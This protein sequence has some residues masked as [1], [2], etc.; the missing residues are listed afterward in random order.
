MTDVYST[1]RSRQATADCASLDIRRWT[2]SESDEGALVKHER[3]DHLGYGAPTEHRAQI[4]AAA[5]MPRDGRRAGLFP[6]DSQYRFIAVD[7][8][9]L[10]RGRCFREH[11]RERAGAAA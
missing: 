4:V 9:D 3:R 5:S 11:E 2:P 1:P 7:P 10:R 6:R 8:D